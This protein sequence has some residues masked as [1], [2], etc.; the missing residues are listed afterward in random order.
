MND[1]MASVR[2]RFWTSV[3]PNNFIIRDGVAKEKVITQNLEDKSKPDKK[4]LCLRVLQ[5]LNTQKDIYFKVIQK[6]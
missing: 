3:C 5:A 2:N 4:V 6:R 1:S